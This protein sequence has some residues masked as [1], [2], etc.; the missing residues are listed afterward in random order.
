MR[1]KVLLQH[2]TGEFGMPRRYAV[3]NSHNRLAMCNLAVDQG[4]NWLMVD[5]CKQTSSIVRSNMRSYFGD[6]QP[7]R[8]HS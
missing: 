8:K 7:V 1:R 5:D 3:T 4:S 6:S 2:I